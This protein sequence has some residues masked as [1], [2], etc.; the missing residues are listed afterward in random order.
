MKNINKISVF[1]AI[2]GAVA[3]G[4]LFFSSQVM[5]PVVEQRIIEEK[6]VMLPVL[7]DANPGAN[8]SGYFH[9]RVVAY[10]T[11][12]ANNITAPGASVY[13][14]SDSYNTSMT[15]QTPFNTPFSIGV[16]VGGTCNDVCW[17]NNNTFN[18]AYAWCLITSTELNLTSFNMTEVLIGQN[19]TGYSWIYYYADNTSGFQVNEG[20]S[21]NFT[22]KFYVCRLTS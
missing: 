12:F 20:G 15:G 14:Y 19:S 6:R 8:V 16:K 5:Q 3:V 2:I 10:G 7:G 22:C 9:V 4:Y 1:I 13:E 11:S 17:S 21:Y 18:P